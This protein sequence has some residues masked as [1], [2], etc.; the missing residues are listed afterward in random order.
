MKTSTPGRGLAFMMPVFMSCF[1]MPAQTH[2]NPVAANKEWNIQEPF[3]SEVFIENKGQFDQPDGQAEMQVQYGI[4]NGGLKMYFSPN[5]LSYHIINIRPKS[6]EDAEEAREELEHPDANTDEKIKDH[7]IDQS[8]YVHLQWLDAN[9]DAKLLVSDPVPDHYSYMVL[10]SKGK[11]VSVTARAFKKLTYQNIYPNIDIEYCFS[12]DAG[13]K[14]GVK[15]TIIVHPGGDLALVKMKY[16]GMNG[17]NMDQ[18]GNIINFI[19]D[20]TITDYAPNLSYVGN[21]KHK[22]KVKFIL[23]EETVSF[24][25]PDYDQLQKL[26]IDPFVSVWSNAPGFTTINDGYTVRA[27]YN[28]N[29]FIMGGGTSTGGGGFPGKNYEVKKFNSTGVLQWTAITAS[30]NLGDYGDMVVLRSGKAIVA[31]GFGSG[32]TVYMLNPATGAITTAFSA[33]NEPGWRFSYN[34]KQNNNVLWVGGGNTNGAHLYKTDTNFAAVTNYCPWTT[35]G[36]TEDICYLA[37]DNS[38]NTIY[39]TNTTNSSPNS[40]LTAP[41]MVKTSLSAPGTASWKVNEPSLMM[42]AGQG[43]FMN[44]G[45]AGFA[46]GWSTG[47]NGM[48]VCSAN[49]YTYDGHII[50]AYN[51]ANGAMLNT[52]LPGGAFDKYSGI[53]VDS[54]HRIYVGCAGVVKRYSSSLA[55]DQSIAVS[56]DVYD[57][58]FDPQDD[59]ILYVTG[60]GFVQKLNLNTCPTCIAGHVT[61]LAGCR[62]GA[63]Q[64][65]SIYD[66]NAVPPFTYNWNNGQVTPKD[67]SL[68]AGIYV[69]TVTDNNTLC[70]NIWKDTLVVGGSPTI[71]T[72]K[73]TSRMAV[74]KADNGSATVTPNGTAPYTYSWSPTGDTTA[75]ITNLSPGTYTCTIHDAGGCSFTTSTVVTYGGTIT[76]TGTLSN[77]ACFGNYSGSATAIPLTG[78]TPYT[79][80]WSPSGGNGATASGLSAGTYI[81]TLTDHNGCVTYDTALIS[82]P[83]SALSAITTATTNVNC[84]GASTGTA[85]TTPAGGTS[86]YTCSWS[87]GQTTF[88]ASGLTAGIYTVIITDHNG[89]SVNQTVTIAQPLA[90]LTDSITVNSNV[91]CTGMATGAATANPAGGTSPYS[92]SWSS[93]QTTASIS[94]LIAGNYTVTL[95]DQNGC[96]TSQTVTISQPHG[97]LYTNITLVSPV[98]CFGT[99]TGSALA[100]PGGGTSPYT[101]SWNNGLTTPTISGLPAGIYTVYVTDHH[102]CGTIKTI[103]IT[104]PSAPLTANDSTVASTCMKQ[105]GSITVFVNG[106]TPGLGYTFNWSPAPA[107]GQTGPKAI[108]LP[109]NLYHCLITDSAGCTTSIG[110]S[111]RNIGTFPV[112]LISMVGGAVSCAGDS[113]LL[114]GHGTGNYLWTPGAWT[115]D[116]ILVKTTGTYTLTVTNACGTASKPTTITFNPQPNPVLTGSADFCFGQTDQLT[117]SVT[118]L[119]PT[120]YLW[121]PGGATTSSI[122]VSTSGTYTVVATNACGST[123]TSFTVNMHQVTAGFT[124]NQFNGIAPL[125][126]LF[127]NQSSTNT[128]TW[129]WNYGDGTTGNGSGGLHTYST[130]GIYTCILIVE[131]AYGCLDTT[132]KIISVRELPSSILVPNVFTPNGD[133]SNDIFFINMTNI[134]SLD[135]TIYDRWGVTLAHL[136]SPDQAWDGNTPSGKRASDGTYYY[137][138]KARGGDDKDYALTGFLMLIGKQ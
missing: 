5:G 86:P 75:T 24:D 111:V 64:V 107:T 134:I 136:T 53:D 115:S 84:F 113:I 118:T 2:H 19:P 52:A 17:I 119:G 135:C 104:Q 120:T 71:L 45:A 25:V 92:F 81:C 65:D 117:A 4:N 100:Q 12:K 56:G 128:V 58:R 40:S 87:N 7:F 6:E 9:P 60:K 57:L 50:R 49:V 77:V 88:S 127:T 90:P 34:L 82:Q 46:R 116:S 31:H 3:K 76:A 27:D 114:I 79:Y 66:P 97:A 1:A 124:D 91:N 8:A 122:Q 37:Q 105:N 68:L 39:V 14:V 41:K 123:T 70:P 74:C 129:Y 10:H 98:N 16:S 78:A 48:V 131:D 110:D 67:T 138:L 106:G 69:V 55:Y 137:I 121:S 35:A 63:A 44:G 130:P 28:H 13:N 125:P 80:S 22:K 36:T 89:C 73:D 15:Y 30:P 32:N 99:A 61:N 85:L 62:L 112:P 96:T 59:N 95:T 23:K 20:G 102:G 11:P 72:A 101:Y 29:V 108:G 103:A 51:G 126:V 133:G 47:V 18:A 38:G 132:S 83:P 42:E 26:V 43:S 94:G 33:K 93:G 109:M 54:C 21:E